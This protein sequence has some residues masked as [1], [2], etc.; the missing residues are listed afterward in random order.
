MPRGIWVESAAGAT[1][2]LRDIAGAASTPGDHQRRWNQYEAIVA[3]GRLRDPA[4]VAV[5][6]RVARSGELEADNRRAAITSL[7][8]IRTAEAEGALVH[9]VDVPEL[10]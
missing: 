5:L 4:S 6:V 9:L 1:R 10:I 8:A 2:P 7:A 3:L